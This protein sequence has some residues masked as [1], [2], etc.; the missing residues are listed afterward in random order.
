MIMKIRAILFIILFSMSALAYPSVI[1][2]APDIDPKGFDKLHPQLKNIAYYI[3]GFCEQHN[4]KFVITSTVRSAERNAQVGGKSL[5][6]V[7]FRAF[8]MSI[9]PVYGWT[10]ELLMIMMQKVEQRYGHLGAYTSSGKQLLQFNHDAG[11]GFHL[12]YQIRRG[13]PWK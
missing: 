12:H 11:N 7:E 5:T 3:A 1:L 10:D 13:L 9:K 4:I 8:D 6:H 2:F